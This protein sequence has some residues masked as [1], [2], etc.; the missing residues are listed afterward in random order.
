MDQSK[1]VLFFFQLFIISVV[2][3]TSMTMLIWKVDQ[4]PFI[5]MFWVSVMSSCIGYILPN[6]SLKPD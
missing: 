5:T 2:I 1:K 4:N 3:I 6:P